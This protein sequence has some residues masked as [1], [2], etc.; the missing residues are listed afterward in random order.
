MQMVWRCNKCGNETIDKPKYKNIS[1]S[2]CGKGRYQGWIQCECGQWFH[3]VRLDQKYCS[4]ECGYKYRKSGGKK[5]KHYPNTQRARTAVCPVCGKTFRAIKD[6]KNKRAIYCSKECWSERASETKE[7]PVCGEMFKIYTSANKKYC[8]I[9]CR[10][11]AYRERK[12][13]LSNFWQGGKV[14]ESKLR[15]SSVEY[16]EWRTAVFKRDNYTCQRCGGKRNIEAHHLKECSRYPEL[17]YDVDNGLTLC[18]EC[19]KETDN[20]GWKARWA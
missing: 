8:S 2:E 15:R 5:G 17:I 18:H 13:E 11:I 4:K 12:G 9:K 20:Y 6:Y 7:C 14:K 3:P 10:N 19:H 1:C 16:K